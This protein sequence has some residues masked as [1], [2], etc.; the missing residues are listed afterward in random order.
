MMSK[1]YYQPYI[2]ELQKR[3]KEL[4]AQ[5]A[6]LIELLQRLTSVQTKDGW[7]DTLLT[8]VLNKYKGE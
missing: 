8:P 7:L 2:D 5:K 1:V 4:E 3:I 6:K